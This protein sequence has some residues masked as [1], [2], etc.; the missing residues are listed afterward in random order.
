MDPWFIVSSA[1]EEAKIIELARK[2]N[3]GKPDWVIGKVEAALSELDN[4]VTATLGISFKSDIDDLR[5]SPSLEIVKRL[6]IENP[7]MDI[8][9]VEPNIAELPD[10]LSGMENVSLQ[11]LEMA[12]SAADLVLLLVDHKEFKALDRARLEG[13]IVIDTRG[14]WRER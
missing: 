6:G 3:N 14:V 1:P 12:L 9:V 2:V 10:S 8:R 4:P 13:K 7:Q 11:D 5:E